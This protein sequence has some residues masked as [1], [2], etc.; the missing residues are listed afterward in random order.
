MILFAFLLACGGGADRQAVVPACTLELVYGD[1]AHALRVVADVKE[2]CAHV[3][4][5]GDFAACRGAPDLTV[6]LLPEERCDDLAANAK[7]VHAWSATVAPELSAACRSE[8][9]CLGW[10]STTAGW[11]GVP[12]L[13]H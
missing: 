3:S 2:A 12:I 6:V 8:P 13:H 5:P 11:G 10:A 4:R 9:S 1:L 7:A